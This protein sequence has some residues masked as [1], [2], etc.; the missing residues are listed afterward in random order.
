MHSSTPFTTSACVCAAASAAASSRSSSPFRRSS[1][2]AL[3]SSGL[4]VT[5][6]ASRTRTSSPGNRWARV[7]DAHLQQQLPFDRLNGWGMSPQSNASPETSYR[8]T[9]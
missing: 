7:G 6:A 5:G 2:P 1:S 9:C 3:A 8:A 4:G